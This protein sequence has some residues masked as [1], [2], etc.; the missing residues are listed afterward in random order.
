MAG[1]SYTVRS[2]VRHAHIEALKRLGAAAISVEVHFDGSHMLAMKPAHFEV[3]ITVHDRLA[4]ANLDSAITQM[5]GFF[6]GDVNLTNR[7]KYEVADFDDDL[8]ERSNKRYEIHQA[9][10][11]LATGAAAEFIANVH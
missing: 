6:T 10:A 11:T 2:K 4:L 1:S 8:I 3:G 5:F 7:V 9:L